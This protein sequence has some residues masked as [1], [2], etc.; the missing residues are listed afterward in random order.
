MEEE[1]EW[2]HEQWKKAEEELTEIYQR[3]ISRKYQVLDM[4]N[5]LKEG[6][7]RWKRMI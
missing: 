7:R 2:N 1:T 5:K 4:F 6:R 3:S